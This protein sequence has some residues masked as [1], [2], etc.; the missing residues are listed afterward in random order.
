MTFSCFFRQ[1]VLN[2]KEVKNVA[3]TT[4]TGM[5]ATQLRLDATTVHHWSGLGDRRLTNEERNT[6]FLLDDNFAKLGHR[7][8]PKTS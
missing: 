5:V 6:T 2:L 1:I 8:L 3:V 4:S 7:L